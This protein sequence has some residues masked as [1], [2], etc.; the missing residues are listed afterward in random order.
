MRYFLAFT[1]LAACGTDPTTRCEPPNGEVVIGVIAP[2]DATEVDR[3]SQTSAQLKAA[4]VA[5]ELANPE[6][7]CG[8]EIAASVL[9]SES[10]TLPVYVVAVGARPAWEGDPIAFYAEARERWGLRLEYR[11]TFG[12]TTYE[13]LTV[14]PTAAIS[15][16]EMA[17]SVVP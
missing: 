9:S 7:V 8:A 1:L 12:A 10:V 2:E 6:T 16:A 13:T 17:T 3:W 11:E 15:V 4:G 5:T 14:E